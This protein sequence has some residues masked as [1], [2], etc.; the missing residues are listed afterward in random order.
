MIDQPAPL[1]GFDELTQQGIQPSGTGRV[2]IVACGALAR[3]I[4]DLKARGGWSHLDLTCLPRLQALSLDIETDPTASR[5]L[6]IAL[7]GCGA[8][9]VLLLT[10]PDTGRDCPPGAVAA[11]WRRRSA[12][13]RVIH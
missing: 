4:L 2:L 8:A 12:V 10:P 1:P 3:E 11:V 13:G 6:S 7:H 5:L 9:E